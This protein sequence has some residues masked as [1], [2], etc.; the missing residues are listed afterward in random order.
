L[1]KKDFYKHVMRLWFMAIKERDIHRL[2]K[3]LRVSKT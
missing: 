2:K 1:I 3:C